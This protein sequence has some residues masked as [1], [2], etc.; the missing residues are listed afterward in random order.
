LKE[1]N[2]SS[3]WRKWKWNTVTIEEIIHKLKKLTKLPKP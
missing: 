2:C 1:I 3:N